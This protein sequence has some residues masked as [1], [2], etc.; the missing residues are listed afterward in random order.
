M[1][2]QRA[3][4]T[5]RVWVPAACFG[6]FALVVLARLAQL[7][8]LDHDRYAAAARDELAANSTIYAT[9]GAILDR[10]GN[11]LASSIETWD[12]YVNA[13]A[14]RDPEVST[15][16]SAILA[17]RL[18]MDS[19]ALLTKI[20]EAE[21]VDVLVARDIDYA[22]GKQILA[23]EL[24]GV[25]LRSNSNRLNPEGDTGA[26]LL[27]FLGLENTGRSGL[28]ATYND[29][30]QGKPGTVIYERDTTGEPI[31]YGQ[32]L[33]SEP[34][35]G[36][37]LVLTIDRYL[38][39]MAESYLATAIEEHKAKGGT[40][41][42]MDPMSGE[43]LALATSPGIKFSTLGDLDLSSPDDLALLNNPAITDLY[44][45]G[46]VMKVITA[47]AAID[48]GAVTPNTTYVD[49]GVVNVYDV[50][51]KNWR[52]LVY[53]T[54]T[55]TG[56]LVDSINT[57][58]V[59]MQ[60]A[61]EAKSSGAFQRYLDAFGFGGATGVDLPGEA[62]PI[63]RRP[64]DENYSPVDLATQSFGQSI[65]VT[66]IQMISAVAAAI[67]GGNLMRPHIVK[68]IVS[69]NGTRKE[70]QPEVVS[71]P[72]TPET[73][74][75]IRQMLHAVVDTPG[76]NHPGNIADYSTGGKSGTAN[77][78]VPNGYDDTQIASFIGFAPLDNPR[79]LVL[80]KLD[81]NQ[82]LETGTE[83]AAP[84]FA[85]IADEALHYLN[86]Q[87]DSVTSVARP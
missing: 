84:V 14:W 44:E 36:K 72:I 17:E 65:S 81:E 35:P 71:H 43:L 77:V 28:E 57:G 68:S 23:D 52:D 30:L 11:V 6:V 24:P 66:P 83:A 86:V 45:P 1:A 31:P 49:T 69:P 70:I 51:I 10:N 41:I 42:M 62:E 21:T 47:A 29:V 25:I 33:T 55:M 74:A 26:S 80:V 59:F 79:V 53:G 34:E 60:Q 48:A 56:V 4:R 54:Q 73:S 63:V 19:G 18:E 40:I 32:Y 9:R 87:P 7:Q 46:S 12:V 64:G 5:R 22:V 85:R 78:P 61:L 16:P 2:Q 15:A 13:R 67:N 75:K 37:D 20:A 58:A 27:G 3:H 8:I 50:P 76:R 82:D 39:Q 38:Q